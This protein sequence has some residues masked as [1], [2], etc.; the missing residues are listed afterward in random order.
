MTVTVGRH[1]ACYLAVVHLS[2]ICLCTRFLHDIY[3]VF[4]CTIYI[5]DG[6][7]GINA[8]FDEVSNLTCSAV[9]FH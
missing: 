8:R 5:T 2:Y 3:A 6:V 9:P 7:Q 1:R 4:V